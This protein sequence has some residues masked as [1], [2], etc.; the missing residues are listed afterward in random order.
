MPKIDG[1]EL[2]R[3]IRQHEKDHGKPRLPIVGLS[4]HALAEVELECTKAG[5]DDFI[6]K[7]VEPNAILAKITELIPSNTNTLPDYSI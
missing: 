6:A 2:T 5:M 1:I 3:R 7:P 4:A